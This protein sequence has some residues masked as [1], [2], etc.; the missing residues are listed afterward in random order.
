MA[1]TL[2]TPVLLASGSPSLQSAGM[3][4]P[5]LPDRF[6][7]PAPLFDYA[8]KD[9]WTAIEEL[10]GG[11]E[12]NDEDP[13]QPSK[14]GLSFIDTHDKRGMNHTNRNEVQDLKRMFGLL[15]HSIKL[16]TQQT[17]GSASGPSLQSASQRAET[18]TE[19][20]PEP[21]LVSILNKR[22]RT[23]ADTNEEDGELSARVAKRVRFVDTED[24]PLPYI[25]SPSPQL[26]AG[27]EIRDAI[28]PTN[29]PAGFIDGDSTL[30]EPA[31]SS[32]SQHF[33][34]CENSLSPPNFSGH[35]PCQRETPQPEYS[36]VPLLLRISP[37]PRRKTKWDPISG[38][39]IPIRSNMPDIL[40]GLSEE[41]D[42][43]QS[44]A[45]EEIAK[46]EEATNES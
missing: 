29:R 36:N 40:E 16:T 11:D 30:C 24:I 32:G 18:V 27:S 45:S 28:T 4:V 23:E 5:Y 1:G 33:S 21:R 10:K 41:E 2:P 22:P 38:R 19:L 31:T 9:V 3:G 42:L 35:S 15:H 12:N 7:Q 37:L 46:V 6:G 25:Q 13:R 20:R 44:Q 43:D 39:R 26:D 8:M 34:D 14:Y 17:L